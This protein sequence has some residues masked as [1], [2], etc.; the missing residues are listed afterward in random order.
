MT[1]VEL[2]KQIVVIRNF[3]VKLKKNNK[4]KSM[5]RSDLY[6]SSFDIQ[7]SSFYLLCADY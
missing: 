5:E 2:L 6:N 4:I 7:H 1:N 3:S